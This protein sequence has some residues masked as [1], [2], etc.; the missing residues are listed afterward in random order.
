MNERRKTNKQDFSPLSTHTSLLLSQ[1]DDEESFSDRDSSL[2]EL[3]TAYP[4]F[5]HNHNKG[6]LGKLKERK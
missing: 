3:S 4:P 6:N 2:K 5:I 1:L